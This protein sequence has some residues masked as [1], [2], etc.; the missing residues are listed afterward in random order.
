M[1]DVD[2]EVDSSVVIVLAH[3]HGAPERVD[4]VHAAAVRRPGEAVGQREVVV[5]HRQL[6]IRLETYELFG[7][8]SAIER[9][10]AHEE[11]SVGIHCAVVHAATFALWHDPRPFGATA[12]GRFDDEVGL[13]GHEEGSI[14]G[15]RKGADHAVELMRRGEGDCSVASEGTFQHGAADD[16]DPQQPPP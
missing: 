2:G 7:L 1:A 9:Q 11:P 10:G 12:I 5:E 3:E 4:A 15:E 16:V 6:T 13:G 8:G 14:V